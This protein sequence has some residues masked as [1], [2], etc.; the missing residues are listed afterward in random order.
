MLFFRPTYMYMCLRSLSYEG[1][2]KCML[3]SDIYEHSNFEH[4]PPR[5]NSNTPVHIQRTK[6]REKIEWKF[7][8][9]IQSVNTPFI[10]QCLAMYQH[11]MY[12]IRQYTCI[13]LRT[14][15]TCVIIFIYTWLSSQDYYSKGEYILRQG[16][17][18]DTFF[19]I[20][21]GAVSII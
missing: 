20:N 1:S 15:C 5:P 3:I 7:Q 18:G 2:A 8:Y 19:I 4:S 12:S 13:L 9:Y 16:S 14:L 6:T 10:F 17:T 21:A 11:A